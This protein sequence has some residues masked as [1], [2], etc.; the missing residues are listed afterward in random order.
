M[1][2]S[3]IIP[4]WNGTKYLKEAV[5]ALKSQGVDLELI[6]VDDGSSD[7][8]GALARSLGC[9]VLRNEVLQGQICGKNQALKVV[10]GDFVLFH[11]CDD[12]MRP[13]ALRRLVDEMEGDSSAEIVMVKLKDFCSPDTPE[14]VKFVKPAPYWGCLSGSTLFRTSVFK[15]IG[16]FREDLIAGDVIDLTQR[17]QAAGV[18]IKKIDFIACDR[19]IH[20]SNYGRT[21]QASEY[22]DYATALCAKLLATHTPPQQN[23][24]NPS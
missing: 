14:Q 16:F 10:T 18:E 20:A 7:G 19:R 23:S 13:G 8:S 6:L 9:R 4:C 24:K 17:C 3:I 15:K 11:D 2:C 22:K 21:N 12:V 5:G 1:K